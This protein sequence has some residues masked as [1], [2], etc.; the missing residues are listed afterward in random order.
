MLAATFSANAQS[1]KDLLYGGKLKTDSG[2][3]IRKGDDLTAKIDTST[4][5]PVETEKMKMTVAT[6]DSSLKGSNTQASIAVVP[7]TG[8][9]DNSTVPKDNN[10]V[11]KDNNKIWKEYID[12]FTSTLKTEVLPSKKIK[13]G[14]YYLLV[15]YE[16]GID[17]Q[18]A[19]NSVSCSPEAS[20]LEQQV[21]ERLTLGAPPMNPVLGTNGKPRKVVKKYNFNVSK[22]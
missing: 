21:K 13:S 22:L 14:T 11:S 19:I 1:I 12:S 8:P 10:S 2:T 9:T 15:E 20:F 4:K 3:V 6:R 7:G 5:K 18:T 17:G 16:I